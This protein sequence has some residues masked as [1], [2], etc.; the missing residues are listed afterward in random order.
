MLICRCNF[1]RPISR[2]T[3]EGCQACLLSVDWRNPQ[4]KT[5]AISLLRKLKAGLFIMDDRSA[6]SCATMATSKCSSLLSYS[7]LRLSRFYRNTQLLLCNKKFSISRVVRLA[8][9][10]ELHCR[11]ISNKC[12]NGASVSPQ[13]K[14]LVLA[15]DDWFRNTHNCFYDLLTFISW[16]PTL[17]LAGKNQHDF[18]VSQ[19]SR[20]F[21]LTNNV[22]TV[23][24]KPQYAIADVKNPKFHNTVPFRLIR[25]GVWPVTRWTKFWRRPMFVWLGTRSKIRPKGK[26]VAMLERQA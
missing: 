6:E 8:P 24:F 15:H 16:W 25:P 10:A 11:Y 9:H 7:Y 19:S 26:R 22:S 23:K 18:E 13:W 1:Q 14:H 5:S 3:N 17:H 4:N 12:H 2:H 21:A 20:L